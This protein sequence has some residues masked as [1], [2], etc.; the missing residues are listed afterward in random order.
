MSRA[1]A[2]A[3]VFYGATGDLAC[4]KIVPALQSMVRR[5]VLRVPVIGVEVAHSRA[6]DLD[7]CEELLGDALRGDTFRFARED[8][9]EEAWRIVD[10]AVKAGTPVHVHEPGTWGPREAAALIAEGWHVAKP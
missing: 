2:D 1:P 10:P 8:Y 5:G 4:R 6:G 9:V 3:L 7:P